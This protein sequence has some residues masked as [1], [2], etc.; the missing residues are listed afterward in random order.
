[1]AV[2]E[3][4]RLIEKA[5]KLSDS[6]WEKMKEELL[7]DAENSKKIHNLLIEIGIPTS[8]K[9]YGYLK[10]AIMFCLEDPRMQKN[11]VDG[12]YSIIAKEYG[13]SWQNVER[14]MRTA[15]KE[16]FKKGNK[17]KLEEIFQNTCY[18]NK[19]RPTNSKFL[20]G[21]VEYIKNS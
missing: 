10:K 9:G 5:R 15:V 20:A 3:K 17:E 16:A 6:E 19:G 18:S 21:I 2:M 7:K 11:L 12:L 4:I 8:M 14:N 1:M 13:S